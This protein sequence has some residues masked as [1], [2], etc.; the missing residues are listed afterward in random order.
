[1]LNILF[2]IYDYF[3]INELKIIIISFVLAI[4]IITVF[5]VLL[6]KQKKDIKSK[7]DKVNCSYIFIVNLQTK[8]VQYFKVFSP[9]KK[10]SIDLDS[11]YNIFHRKSKEE[12]INWIKNLSLKKPLQ[13]NYFIDLNKKGKESILFKVINISNDGNMIFLQ[14]D[15]F[16]NLNKTIINH[17]KSNT[18]LTE[19]D[20]VSYYNSLKAR[21]KKNIS[22][23]FLYLFNHFEKANNNFSFRFLTLLKILDEIA[24]YFKESHYFCFLNNHKLCIIDFKIKNNKEILKFGQI[25]ESI[26]EKIISL[27]MQNKMI[28]YRICVLAQLNSKPFDLKEKISAAEDFSEY[29]KN[30]I[31]NEKLVYFNKNVNLN[32][33][34][35]SVIVDEV[36]RILNYNAFKVKAVSFINNK[37]EKFSGYILNFDIN[38][39]IINNFD[40]FSSEI[41]NQ[42]KNKEC[43]TL[44]IKDALCTMKNASSRIKT[45]ALFV[46]IY[47]PFLESL[48]ESMLN[49]DTP[50]VFII[51]GN[52]LNI[53]FNNFDNTKALLDKAKNLGIKLAL[54]IK[55]DKAYIKDDLL[56]YFSYVLFTK[57]IINQI[58]P[59]SINRILIYEYIKNHQEQE[60][61]A[62]DIDSW[63]KS[64][65]YRMIGI[66]YFSGPIIEQAKEVILD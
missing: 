46:P 30:S 40:D 57:D 21:K 55:S 49:F 1:M 43:L 42:G 58:A 16:S 29:A 56:D 54:L 27:E 32:T 52:I 7:L 41:Y 60:Y 47:F 44:V 37:N 18:F 50:M 53:W 2:N 51:D 6:S 15:N 25:L 63:S 13:K 4:L 35:H 14:E 20:I 3:T 24:P 28:D 66:N 65:L 8:S 64:E 33:S 36:N 38:S 9:S 31:D 45:K 10:S 61:I 26:T 59:E 5:L 39:D 22:I 48:D 34:Y 12:F 23:Y 17:N 11:F 19:N 62:L